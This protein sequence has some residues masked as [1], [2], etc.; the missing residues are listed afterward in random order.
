MYGPS[1][2][3]DLRSYLLFLSSLPEVV[4][5]VDRQ[6]E[7]DRGVLLRADLRQGLEIPELQRN[8]L[9]GNGGSGIGQRLRSL[10]FPLR[11]NN[12]G[13]FFPFRLSLPGHG[14]LHV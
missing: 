10:K 2:S 3:S 13:Q 8:R 6:R 4:Q 1:T 7:D 11:M 5:N 12:F 9:G 14:S